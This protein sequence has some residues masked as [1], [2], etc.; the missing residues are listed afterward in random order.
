MRHAPCWSG[1]GADRIGT[2]PFR[3]RTQVIYVY[4]RYWAISSQGADLGEHDGLDFEGGDFPHATR[5]TTNLSSKVNL[6][7]AI[8]FRALCGANLVTCPATWGVENL[9][10]HD[11]LDFEPLQL[12][13]QVVDD[14]KV[15]TMSLGCR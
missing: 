14:L 2:G 8:D 15:D 3:A 6:H 9:G 4:L 10:E 11:S 13:R 12:A 1:E 7:H 5:W